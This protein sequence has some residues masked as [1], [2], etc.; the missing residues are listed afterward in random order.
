VE[1][2]GR[3]DDG[4]DSIAKETMS[5]LKGI[6]G[7]ESPDYIFCPVGEGEL[8]YKLISSFYTFDHVAGDTVQYKMVPLV[9]DVTPRIIGSTVQNSIFA[10][11]VDFIP[12]MGGSFADKLPTGYSDFKEL[13]TALCQGV[14]EISVIEESGI[15]EE[16]DIVRS[17]KINAEPSAAAAFAGCRKHSIERG[18]DKDDVVV[19]VN[20]GRGLYRDAN[21]RHQFYL[22]AAAGLLAFASIFTGG[23]YAHELYADYLRKQENERKFLEISAKELESRPELNDIYIYALYRGGMKEVNWG[24]FNTLSL[25]YISGDAVIREMYNRGGE[26]TKTV[27]DF[28][29]WRENQKKLDEFYKNK[30]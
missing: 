21:K 16:Y 13:L 10:Y 27:D 29:R 7:I 23:Y 12:D 17:H 28:R 22:R 8:M 4:Y 30:K 2:M 9:P 25:Y 14:N 11:P 19:I 1:G 24:V 6:Y 15:K 18:F 20:T 26:F 3:N 5:Q